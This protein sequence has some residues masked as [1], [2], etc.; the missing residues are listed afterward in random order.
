M[1]AL[2]W[3]P[4]GKRKRSRPRNTWRGSLEAEIK[5]IGKSWYQLERDVQNLRL[6]RERL[7][8]AYAPE[9]EWRVNTHT[10]RSWRTGA[11]GPLPWYPSLSRTKAKRFYFD[12]TA[13]LTLNA[14]FHNI[15]IILIYEP[16][17]VLRKWT[18]ALRDVTF[19]IFNNAGSWLV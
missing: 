18:Q 17:S 7:L 6:W 15:T 13:N 5:S 10:A 12:D 11:F 8:M 2:T 19:P 1:Q 3:N 4:Q 9:K 14:A 16:S